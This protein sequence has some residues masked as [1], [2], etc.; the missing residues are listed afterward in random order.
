[1]DLILD[2][3]PERDRWLSWTAPRWMTQGDILFFYHTKNAKRKI[4]KLLKE[5]RD[6]EQ[7]L[8]DSPSRASA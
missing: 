1:M 2:F 4:Q 7:A 8:R 5:A 3:D 6:E